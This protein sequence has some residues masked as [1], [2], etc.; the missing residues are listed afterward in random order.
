ARGSH[1]GPTA[2]SSEGRPAFLACLRDELLILLLGHALRVLRPLDRARSIVVGEGAGLVPVLR[3]VPA[4]AVGEADSLDDVLDAVRDD[5]DLVVDG[6]PER[7]RPSALAVQPDLLSDS[8]RGLEPL[9]LV[10]VHHST[11][12]PRREGLCPD[13][14]AALR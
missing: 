6:A 11:P 3:A 5:R 7:R 13:F 9:L 1:G 14:T 4:H 2:W 10:P 12:R 8:R